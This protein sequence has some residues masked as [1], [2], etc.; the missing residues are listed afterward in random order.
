MFEA[1]SLITVLFVGLVAGWLASLIM[2][3]GGLIRDLVTGLIGAFVG[4]LIVHGFGV[5]LPIH[6][7]LI[8]DIVISTIG[9]VVVVAIARIVA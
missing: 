5:P 3:G 2:G 9:A 1:H 8:A 4:S 6:N 7:P